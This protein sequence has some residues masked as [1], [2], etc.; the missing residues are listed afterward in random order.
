[1]VYLQFETF[2][3]TMYSNLGKNGTYIYVKTLTIHVSASMIVLNSR[4]QPRNV[5]LSKKCAIGD[6]WDVKHVMSNC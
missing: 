3:H 2:T 1:M 4:D 5:S 6:I